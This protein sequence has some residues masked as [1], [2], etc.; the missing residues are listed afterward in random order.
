MNLRIYDDKGNQVGIPR[1]SGD[2]PFRKEDNTKWKL[3]SPRERG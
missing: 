3:Y 2:E 1:V